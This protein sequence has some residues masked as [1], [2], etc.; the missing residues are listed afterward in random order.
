MNQQN[1]L[2][3]I[4]IHPHL[5]QK[6]M[7]H[8]KEFA[9]LLALYSFYIYH[10]QLQKTNQPLATDE[11]T[12][13]GL[14]WAME[15]VKK[16]KRLLKEMKIIEVVQKRKFYYIHLFFI[17]TK[18]KINELMQNDKPQNVSKD[19]PKAK[20]KKQEKSS[21]EKTLISNQ[22]HP[23]KIDEIMGKLFQIK[24]VEKY[25]FSNEVFTKWLIYCE[26]RK[27]KYTKSHL[28]NWLDVLDKRTTIEQK[29][30]IY[31]AISKNW[32][33]F[34]IVPIKKSQYHHFLGR[35]I[36]AE[37]YC[38]K[39]IDV[40]IQNDIFLYQFKNMKVRTQEPI[41]KLFDRCEY[42]NTENRINSNIFDVIKGVVKKF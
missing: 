33:N 42:F 8:K 1:I 11:F 12:R 5:M 4:V 9:N 32:Q 34:Y 7:S 17:Y 3:P 6:F 38:E 18:K 21:F 27:L 30:A 19:I 14:N 15:R 16:T 36:K 35:S 13:R 2:N 23:K 40:D 10:A 20:E 28:K 26:K 25:I 22:L 39:L 41:D 29:E 31:T 37:R 24:G